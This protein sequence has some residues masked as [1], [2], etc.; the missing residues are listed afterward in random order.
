MEDLKEEKMIKIEFFP[1]K[2]ARLNDGRI[3]VAFIT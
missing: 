2:I 1:N 3:V